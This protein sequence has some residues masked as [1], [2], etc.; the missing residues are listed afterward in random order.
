MPMD[1]N[2]TPQTATLPHTAATAL[3]VHQRPCLTAKKRTGSI[4]HQEPN[5][6]PRATSGDGMAHNAET[7]ESGT[8]CQAF[9]PSRSC[10]GSSTKSTPV[11]SAA[12]PYPAVALGLLIACS[13]PRPNADRRG[14]PVGHFLRVTTQPG[15]SVDDGAAWDH[16]SATRPGPS[17][18]AR[19]VAGPGGR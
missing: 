10:P 9:L 14:Q 15:L 2:D 11:S 19:L 16:H 13:V 8:Y 17:L 3:T 6:A 12:M 4:N 1:H 5:G 18:A 7:R